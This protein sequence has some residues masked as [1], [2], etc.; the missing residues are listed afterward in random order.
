MSSAVTYLHINAHARKV[1]HGYLQEIMES[2][3]MGAVTSK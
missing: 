3:S 1:A 2:L